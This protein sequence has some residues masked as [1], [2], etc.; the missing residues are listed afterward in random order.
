MKP[1]Q[2]AVRARLEQREH[3]KEPAQEWKACNYTDW[4]VVVRCSAEQADCEAS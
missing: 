4:A 3:Q 1:E 2:L